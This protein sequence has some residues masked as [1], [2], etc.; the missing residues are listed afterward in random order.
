MV[1]P[2]GSECGPDEVGEIV[3]SRA[4]RD[5]RL[6]GRPR[7]DRRG[8]PRRLVPLGDAGS[9]DEEGFLYIRDRYKDMIISGGENVYPAE[10]ESALLEL[11]ASR[12]PP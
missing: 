3:L 10:I 1:R 2:D 12:R 11:D 9:T 6:L 5:G 4:E 8:D 7:A